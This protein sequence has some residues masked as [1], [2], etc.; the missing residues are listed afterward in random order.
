MNLLGI[1]GSLR[2]HSLNTALLHAVGKHLGGRIRWAMADF[3]AVPLYDGEPA[4]GAAEQ[5]VE[6]F[7]Q[8]IARADGVLIA[9]PEYNYS[10]PGALKNALDWASRPA[11]QSVFRNKAV[12]VMSVSPGAIGAVRAQAHL[13]GILLGMAAQVFPYP[14]FALGGAATKFENGELSDEDTRGRLHTYLADFEAWVAKV[15]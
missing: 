4:T 11:Y 13:K 15:R 2:E 8:D 1:S 6:R 3:R 10:V 7:K 14:E 5:A 12:G 9:T